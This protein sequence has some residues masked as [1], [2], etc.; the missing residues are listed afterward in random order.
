MLTQAAVES[1]ETP[2]LVGVLKSI[3][4]GASRG[5]R[6]ALQLETHCPA[7]KRVRHLFSWPD[8]GFALDA[9]LIVPSPCPRGP[10]TGEIAVGLD[11]ELDNVN[12]AILADHKVRLRRWAVEQRL[13]NALALNTAADRIALHADQLA[14]RDRRDAA[15]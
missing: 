9:V 11:R 2:L 7:C 12:K 6:P 1:G 13:A 5:R 15:S 8:E 10:F 3:R 4:L 14:L